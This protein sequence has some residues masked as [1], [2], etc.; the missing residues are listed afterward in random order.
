MIKLEHISYPILI[1][2]HIIVAILIAALPFLIKPIFYVV[3]MYFFYRV[4]SNADRNNEALLACAYLASF[5]VILR[6]TNA[7]FYYEMIKYLII[8]FMLLG[9]FYRGFSLKSIPFFLYL[10]LLVPSIIVASQNIPLGES[11]RKSVAFNLAGPVTLGIVALYC[12][13]QKLTKQ[14][15]SE[16]LKLAIGPIVI[17]TMYLFLVTPNIQ[18]VV[19]STASN[20]AA[21]GGYGP[22]Q[23]ATV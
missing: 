16:I 7:L 21:S 22:N 6:M 13:Q 14:R 17:L 9:I 18:D 3:L 5:E 8:I 4:T 20:F 23:V 19:T 11:L 12:Y 2:A 1:S 15:L 10:L